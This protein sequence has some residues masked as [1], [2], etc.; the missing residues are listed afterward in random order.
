ML[1]PLF[2]QKAPPPSLA[3]GLCFF[4]YFGGMLLSLAFQKLLRTPDIF[5]AADEQ[6]AALMKRFGENIQ[7]AFRSVCGSSP[8]LLNNI[9]KRVV[10][11]HQPQLPFRILGV[12]GIAI[13]AAVQQCPMYIGNH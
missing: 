12:T 10:L 2:V 5:L 7:D 11:V 9:G 8:G 1:Y 6:R 13:D 3:A 4:F